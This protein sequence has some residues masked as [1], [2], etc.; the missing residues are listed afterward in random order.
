M[1]EL[2]EEVSTL[3]R[4][5]CINRTNRLCTNLVN[6]LRFTVCVKKRNVGPAVEGFP[7]DYIDFKP[8]IYTPAKSE[9]GNKTQNVEAAWLLGFKGTENSAEKKQ[10]T[11]EM[12]DASFSYF[13]QKY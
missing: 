3:H 12:Q 5:L 10:S 6:T 1:S 11:V 8:Q 7:A 13:K 9:Q 4:P 2:S